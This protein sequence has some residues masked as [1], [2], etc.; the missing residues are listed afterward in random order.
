MADTQTTEI[1]QLVIHE[2]KLVDERR[3]DEW[4]ALMSPDVEYWVPAW[5]KDQPT[6]DPSTELSLIHYDSRQGLEDRVFRLRLERSIASESLPRTC[7]YVTNIICTPLPDD[8]CRCEANWQVHSW[9]N[10][11]TTTFWGRY[12]YI[13]IRSDNAHGWQIQKKKILLMNDVIPTVLDIYLL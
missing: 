4:L 11:E 13:L 6:M 7:H 2:S 1:T 10:G 8:A 3:W 12:D 5:E 9:R